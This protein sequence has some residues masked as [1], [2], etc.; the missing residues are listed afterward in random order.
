MNSE[1]VQKKDYFWF[2]V[3]GLAIVLVGVIAMVKMSENEKYDP[4]RQQLDE[5]ASKMNIRVLKQY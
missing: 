4:I 1:N 3:A 2:Y 5:E